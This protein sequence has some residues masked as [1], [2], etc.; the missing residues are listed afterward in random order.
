MIPAGVSKKTGKPYDAFFG[1][2]TYGCKG[3]IRIPAGTQPGAPQSVT[4]GS[5]NAN[6]LR[7]VKQ[8]IL[9]SAIEGGVIQRIDEGEEEFLEKWIK[10]VYKNTEHDKKLTE[11]DSPF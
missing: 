10:W 6:E 9:K 1:C 11:T 3:T 2:K 8:A 4:L 5:S 7:I